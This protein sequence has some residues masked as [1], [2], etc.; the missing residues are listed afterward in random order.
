MATT[1]NKRCSKD[2]EDDD[3]EPGGEADNRAA[4]LVFRPK[5]L[6]NET[7][8]L[9]SPGEAVTIQIK[10]FIDSRNVC[11]I[12]N[13]IIFLCFIFN[14]NSTSAN[15]TEWGESSERGKKP[16]LNE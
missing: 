11:I 16:Q 13:Y 6:V 12:L 14:Q 8:R 10:V 15:G 9:R 7:P 2:D 5:S 3:T 1:T 4:C